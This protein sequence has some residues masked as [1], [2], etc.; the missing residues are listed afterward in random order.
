[1]SEGQELPK[2]PWCRISKCCGEACFMAEISIHGVDSV[3]ANVPRCG[4][5]R[6]LKVAGY[7]T[8]YAGPGR[9]FDLAKLRAWVEAH[10]SGVIMPGEVEGLKVPPALSQKDLAAGAEDYPEEPPF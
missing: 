3:I 7:F 9:S 8:I 5:P 6:C 1:M 2:K 4:N 10:R